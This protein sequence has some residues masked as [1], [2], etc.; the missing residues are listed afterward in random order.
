MERVRREFLDILVA[1]GPAEQSSEGDTSQPLRSSTSKSRQVSFD[2]QQQDQQ[3][4]SSS[5]KSDRQKEVQAATA[6]YQRRQFFIREP[7]N[8]YE[9]AAYMA[10][11]LP[12]NYAALSTVLQELQA[13]EPDFSPRSLFDFGSGLGTAVWAADQLWPGRLNEIFAVDLNERMNELSRELLQ[14]GAS[15]DEAI[16][17]KVFYRQ[18]LPVKHYVSVFCFGFYFNIF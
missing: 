15:H 9:C 5:L 6:N 16:L 11:R 2:D 4:S 14:K 18:F 1:Q 7:Y 17:E 10:A 8:A 3:R 13:E 12:A